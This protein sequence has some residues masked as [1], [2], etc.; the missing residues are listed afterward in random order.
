MLPSGDVV[1]SCRVVIDRP[2]RDRGP[3]GRVRVDALDCSIWSATLRRRMSTWVDGDVVEV[4]GVLRRRFWQT[5]SGAQSRIEVEV[6]KAK[7]LARA[8]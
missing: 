5:G 6:R 2:V 4:T 7:R 3:Q 8:S 1:L